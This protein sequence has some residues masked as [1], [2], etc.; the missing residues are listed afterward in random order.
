MAWSTPDSELVASCLSSEATKQ[1]VICYLCGYAD[2]LAPDCP[3]SSASSH[4][5]R[6]PPQLPGAWPPSLPYPALGP[7]QPLPGAPPITNPPIKPSD[8]CHNYNR[9][10]CFR[11]SCKRHT[12]ASP[13]RAPIPSESALGSLAGDVP[14][15]VH[16]I[17]TPLRPLLFARYL[18]AHPDS[19][20]TSNL[21]YS[22]LHGFRI[23]YS[24]PHVAS[25]ASNLTPAFQHPEVIDEA[26]HKER[27]ENRIAGPYTQP[28]F[29]NLICSG[30]GTV[31][32]SDGSWRLIYHLSAPPGTSINDF[33]DPT[34]YS[35][36]YHTIDDAINICCH[37]GRNALLAKVDLKNAFRLCPVHPEDWHL[38]GIRWRGHYLVD[39]CLPFGLRSAP[40]L[41]N[42]VADAIQWILENHCHVQHSFHYLDDYFF[43]GPSDS[44]ACGKSLS[45]MLS[46]CDTLNIPLKPE[47]MVGPTTSLTFLGVELDTTSMTARLPQDKLTSLLS[48]LHHFAA[49][50]QPNQV[51]LQAGPSFSDWK[52][53]LCL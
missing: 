9:R 29:P 46:L 49:I 52:A 14:I 10:T 47:K 5:F 20:F 8:I 30:L 33:I 45:S 39:K 12:S 1:R 22:L 51:L 31:P 35:L 50:Y 28:P 21:I 36:Q 44:Q 2:H 15:H 27:I 19:A 6:Q 32:K 40:F 34:E 7:H 11:T 13:A 16:T 23:G 37:L 25:T 4:S 53:C 48:E 17:C 26:L 42:M 3:K 38:L 43:E 41:F 24:G 18:Q